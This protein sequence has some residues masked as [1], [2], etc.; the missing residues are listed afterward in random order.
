ML[1]WLNKKQKQICFNKN[2]WRSL[3]LID[4]F[5]DHTST[6]FI[7]FWFLFMLRIYEG[8]MLQNY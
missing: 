6:N 1:P 4:K 3:P 7:A 8:D 2:H 5:V